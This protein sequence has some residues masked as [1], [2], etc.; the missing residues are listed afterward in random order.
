MSC[1][2]ECR[3]HPNANLIEDSRAGDMICSEC[4][5]IVGDRVIDVGSEWR[6]FS[7]DSL[8]DDR[9]RVGAQEDPLLGPD[10]ST[11]IGPSKQ[12]QTSYTMR[13][14]N[15]HKNISQT[16]LRKSFANISNIAD[17]INIPNTITMRAKHLFKMVYEKKTLSGRSHDAI[18]AACIY[19]ACRQEGVPRSFNE[20]VG[21]SGVSKVKIGRCFQRILKEFDINMDIINTDDFMERFCRNLNLSN[22]FGKVALCIAKATSSLDIAPGRSPIS[23]VAASIYMANKVSENYEK[24][25]MKEIADVAGV[26]KDTIS[27][28][29]KLMLPWAREICPQDLQQ[30]M[31]ANNGSIK[32]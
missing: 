31:I 4:G 16:A 22:T 7:N 11:V 12:G 30:K 28:S 2:V 19:I 20:I 6:T 10:L 26:T 5:L 32:I 9:S 15:Q 29:Y 1:K 24:R 25:S 8:G 18:G 14:H 21:A 3:Y 13:N 23:I 17:R 27:H